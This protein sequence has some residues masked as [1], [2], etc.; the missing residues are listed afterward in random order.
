MGQFTPKYTKYRRYRYAMLLKLSNSISIN[1]YLSKF[2]SL[3]F[4]LIEQ[5][6]DNNY[7]KISIIKLIENSNIQILQ[8]P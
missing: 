8:I 6:N 5:T 1:S 3:T 7:I 4:L 2:Y